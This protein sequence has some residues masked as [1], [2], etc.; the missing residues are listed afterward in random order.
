[1][2]MVLVVVVMVM[3]VVLYTY[4]KAYQITYFKDVCFSVRHIHVTHMSIKL[5]LKMRA[6]IDNQ[7]TFLLSTWRLHQAQVSLRSKGIQDRRV[8]EYSLKAF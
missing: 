6:E 1:M 4:I 7:E 3:V 2:F 5:F 8:Q